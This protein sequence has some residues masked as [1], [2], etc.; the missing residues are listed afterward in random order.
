LPLTLSTPA[1]ADTYQFFNLGNA[2]NHNLYGI[3][4]NGTVVIDTQNFGPGGGL[5][6]DTYTNGSLTGVTTT[7]PSLSYDNG[8]SCTPTTLPAVQLGSGAS[9][10]NGALEVYYGSFLSGPPNGF[11]KGIFTGPGVGDYLTSSAFPLID[12]STLDQAVLN[13]EGDFAWAD[14][15]QETIFEAVDVSSATTPEPGS[16]LLLA[17][18]SLGLAG[19]IRRRFKP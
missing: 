18:G 19:A 16:L 1:R 14:G 7:A 10:C 3:D 13:S 6:Y 9:T 15:L 2:N 12:S 5:L 8:T 4:G 17:T 11:T